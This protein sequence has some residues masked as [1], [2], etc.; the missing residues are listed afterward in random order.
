MNHYPPPMKNPPKSWRD[1]YIG[2][3]TIQ[4]L[5]MLKP[6]IW[7]YFINERINELKDEKKRDNTR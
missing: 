6:S 1:L 5:E 7:D 4:Q 3:L 2:S